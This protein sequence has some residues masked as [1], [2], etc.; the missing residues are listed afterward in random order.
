MDAAPP[1]PLGVLASG[2]GS[3]LKNLLQSGFRVAAVATNRPHCGAAQI[4]REWGSPL[5]EFPQS[6]YDS[7]VER[8]RAMVTWFKAQGAELIVNAGYD[9]ILD[10][11]F[12]H[13]FA[14]RILNLHPSLLPAF[15]GSMDAVEQALR[16]GVKLTGCTVH[17]VVEEVDAGPI[18]LQAAVPVLDGDSVDTLRARIQAEEHRILPEAIRLLAQKSPSIRQ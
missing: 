15:G 12:V 3:N 6:R 18:L 16:A 10:P 14:D 7:R 17:L 9:R 8:D 1:I 4:A 2:R 13:A 5:G 11:V